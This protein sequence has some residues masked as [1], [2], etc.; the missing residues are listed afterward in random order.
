MTGKNNNKGT[1]LWPSQGTEPSTFL[2]ETTGRALKDLESRD[3]QPTFEA[4][5]RGSQ[6]SDAKNGQAVAAAVNDD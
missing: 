2:Q 5:K 1:A 3:K 6:W 4:T